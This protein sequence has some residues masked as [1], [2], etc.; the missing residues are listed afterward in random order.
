MLIS[1]TKKRTNRLGIFDKKMT[2]I[3]NQAEIID[4]KLLIEDYYS[5]LTKK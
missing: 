2:A 5:N 3:E 4:I 1:Q